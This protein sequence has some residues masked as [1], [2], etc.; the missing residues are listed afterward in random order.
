MGRANGAPE[1]ARRLLRSQEHRAR[2]HGNTLRSTVPKCPATDPNFRILAKQR[3][4]FTRSYFYIRDEVLGAMVMRVACFFAFPDH[5]FPERAQ[6]YRERTESAEGELA[7]ERQCL[8]LRQICM[9]LCVR[10][11]R[12]C[13][14]SDT[15]RESVGAKTFVLK[16]G[17]DDI[18]KPLWVELLLRLGCTWSIAFV[19]DI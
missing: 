9:H 1:R 11:G 3:S 19:N 5:L 13:R 17:K 12:R 4:R 6:L 10:A 14:A 16:L 18:G 7:Q 15:P 8:D 2:Q